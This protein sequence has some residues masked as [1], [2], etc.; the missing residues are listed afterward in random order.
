MK[1]RAEIKAG[2]LLAAMK[3]R[4]ER[5]ANGWRSEINIATHSLIANPSLPKLSDLG[6]NRSQSSQW[7]KLAANLA[8]S[9]LAEDRR[10]I[11]HRDHRPPADILPPTTSIRR[12]VSGGSGVS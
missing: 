10:C 7:Q 6:I 11:Q 5:E 9:A 1:L 4:G 12:R 8:Q 3:A 2:E